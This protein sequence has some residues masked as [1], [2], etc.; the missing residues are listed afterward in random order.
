MES[1]WKNENKNE[2][3]YIGF[4]VMLWSYFIIS[5]NTLQMCEL[6]ITATAPVTGKTWRK[7]N[8]IGAVSS[9]VWAKRD[10]FTASEEAPEIEAGKRLPRSFFLGR[11]QKL[12]GTVMPGF[13]VLHG[14]ITRSVIGATSLSLGETNCVVS[15]KKQ[16]SPWSG[17]PALQVS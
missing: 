4:C 6:K 1:K 5:P 11:S 17:D 2:E 10:P 7:S 12:L 9:S 8:L 14:T 15:K 3:W 13:I 16:R